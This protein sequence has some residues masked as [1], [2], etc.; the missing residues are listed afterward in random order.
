MQATS[1]GKLLE[2]ILI[3]ILG[4]RQ[5]KPAQTPPDIRLHIDHQVPLYIEIDPGALVAAS[6]TVP[7]LKKAMAVAASRDGAAAYVAEAIGARPAAVKEAFSGI[8]RIGFW[9]LGWGEDDDNFRIMLVIE[10][11]DQKPVLPALIAGNTKIPQPDPND[12]RG[13][14]DGGHVKMSYNGVDIHGLRFRRGAGLWAAEH[15]GK[16]AIASDPL[17]LHS[18]ILNAKSPA[19]ATARKLRPRK[20]GSI[21]WAE[22]NAPVAL[23]QLIMT[24]GRHDMNEM[25]WMTTFF[26]FTAWQD[27]SLSLTKDRLAFQLAIA[28]ASKL[29]NILA[30]P[31]GPPALLSAVPDKCDLGFIVSLKDPKAL[32]QHIRSG[33]AEIMRFHGRPERQNRIEQEIREEFG[34]D[35]QKDL[36]DNIV[37]GGFVV[38]VLKRERDLENS[39]VFL[40]QAKDAAKAEVSLRKFVARVMRGERVTPMTVGGAKVWTADEGKAALVG[41]IAMAGPTPPGNS[42]VDL[43]IKAATTKSSEMGAVLPK[44]FPG[45]T[46]FAMFNPSVLPPFRNRDLGRLTAGASFRSGTL[47]LEIDY[48]IAKAAGAFT[49][50]VEAAI[51]RGKKAQAINNL[52]LLAKAAQAYLSDYAKYPVNLDQM[53]KYAGNDRA[54]FVSPVT[55]KPYVFNKKVAGLQVGTIPDRGTTVLAHE[56]PAGLSLHGGGHV[57]YLDGNVEWL[58][59]ARFKRVIEAR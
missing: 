45:A 13:R 37:A 27:A 50:A 38:P 16:V 30:S 54:L 6:A 52:R 35:I 46:S 3:L 39:F 33:F 21:V 36:I 26:D 2:M 17:A 43:T 42:G 14:R 56:N 47:K 25:T 23:N 18:F 1:F 9:L 12:R 11:S 10:R 41:R 29:N 44:R 48:N 4:G 49:K 15:G 8:Q 55:G 57:V 53:A 40:A 7:E 59:T 24:V 51:L 28:P 32:W 19:S 34:I 58:E 20:P 5:P 22:A 31:S